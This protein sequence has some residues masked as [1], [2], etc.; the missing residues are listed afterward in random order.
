MWLENS[1]D[2]VLFFVHGNLAPKDDASETV[3]QQGSDCEKGWDDW[4]DLGASSAA[5]VA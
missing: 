3:A 1:G 2:G 4:G 5:A